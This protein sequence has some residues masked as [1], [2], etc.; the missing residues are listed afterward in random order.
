MD[1]CKEELLEIS[2]ERWLTPEE[3]YELLVNYKT[4]DI[5]LTTS[6]INNPKGMKKKTTKKKIF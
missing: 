5:K 2:N 6:K 3:I 4:L 1:L